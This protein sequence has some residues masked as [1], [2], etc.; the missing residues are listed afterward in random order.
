[1]RFILEKAGHQVAEAHNGLEALAS[2]GIEPPDPNAVLP[3]LILL[4]IMMP[5]MD[6]HT[7]AVRIRADPRTAQVPIIIVT[8][9]GDVRSLFRSVPSVVAYFTKPFDPKSLREAVANALAAK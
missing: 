8:A 3:D 1:M 6:G 9:K 4:D 5:V 2:L 7:A